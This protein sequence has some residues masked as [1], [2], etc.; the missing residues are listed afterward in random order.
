MIEGA[1]AASGTR[2]IA[3]SVLPPI[4]RC[5]ARLTRGSLVR[6]AVS[7]SMVVRTHRMQDVSTRNSTSPTLT[8]RQAS[9]A[10]ASAPRTIRFGRNL[11]IGTGPSAE[12]GP[13][14]IQVFS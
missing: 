11:V 4:L 8:R 1:S 5:R 6:T 9:S 2:F 14:A 13:S 12:R 10:N 3:N 7:G